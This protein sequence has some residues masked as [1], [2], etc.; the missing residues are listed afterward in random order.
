MPLAPTIPALQ[1]LP[2]EHFS[3]W[4]LDREWRRVG[5]KVARRHARSFQWCSEHMVSELCRSS[6]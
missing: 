3:G 2:P 5:Q 1:A 6:H 4:D